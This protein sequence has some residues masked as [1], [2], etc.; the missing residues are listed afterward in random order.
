MN[1][2]VSREFEPPPPVVDPDGNSCSGT[3]GRPNPAD[4]LMTPFDRLNLDFLP[5]DPQGIFLVGGTVRDLIAGRSPTDFD[6]VVLGDVVQVAAK[7]AAKTGGR[8][9]NLGQKGFDCLRVV[10]PQTSID[11]TPL[12]HP[13]IEVDLLNR[14]FTIN[15][16]AYNV[17]SHCLLDGCGGLMDLQRRTVRMVSANAFENDP[18]RLV[19]AYRMAATLGFSLSA[20]TRAAIGKHHHR[21]TTVAAERV[22]SELL[23]IFNAQASA[24]H[25]RDMATSG[26]LTALFPEL[27]PTIGCT[28]NRHHRW[29]VFD[30]SLRTY[31]QLET[32]LSA[33]DNLFS[34][35]AA[36]GGQA[37]WLDHAGVLKYSALLHDVGKPPTRQVDPR[38]AVRFPGHAA[39]GAQIA[40]G[41]SRRLRLSNRQRIAADAVI[42]HHIRPLF[43]FLAAQ[44]QTLGHSG[45]VRFFN[46]C[47]DMTR[48]IVAH[49]MADIS[50]KNDLHG[51]RDQAFIAFCRR[52]I[53]TYDDYVNRRAQVP[54]LISGRDLIEV[55]GLTPCP[56]FRKILQ[57][58]D[59][60][61]LSGELTSRDQALKWVA[62]YLGRSMPHAEA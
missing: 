14:D 2:L 26:L 50:A 23:K 58:V 54:P 34:K 27:N 56:D 25:I 21:I 35:D 28:Q 6:L 59:L 3:S 29:D 24:P 20:E 60:G 48:S 62:A 9:V 16:M 40:A 5:D 17:T 19:R 15:A 57:R 39:K 31:G 30:H 61:R 49:A 11:I 47:G 22:W 10:S 44:N 36:M 37:G 43:L 33:R 55:F 42:R 51:D 8:I 18:V 45:M 7:I 4:N 52:L 41:I 12:T 32:L 46:H 13:S 38:G 1:P 53:T